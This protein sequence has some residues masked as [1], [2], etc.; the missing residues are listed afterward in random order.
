MIVPQILV[1]LYYNTLG[2]E[3]GR[4]TYMPYAS[5]RYLRFPLFLE[6]LHASPGPKEITLL[7]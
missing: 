1:C 5:E 6:Y 2:R 3:W 7:Y 4:V